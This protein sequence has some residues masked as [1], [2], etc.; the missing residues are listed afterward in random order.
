MTRDSFRALWR[1]E[2]PLENIQVLLPDPDAGDDSWLARR[3]AENARH[4]KGYGGDLLADQVRANID[5]LLRTADAGSKPELRLFDLPNTCRIIA[6]EH[7]VYLT[8]YSADEHARNSPCGVPE[9]EQHVRLRAE[10]VHHDV[11]RRPGAEL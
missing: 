2:G 4:D 5:Y 10:V 11:E 1:G 7:V 3:E 9:P 8:P 6:T